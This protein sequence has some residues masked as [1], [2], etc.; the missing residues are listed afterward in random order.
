MSHSDSQP[1][2]A[3]VARDPQAASDS[4]AVT[5]DLS[6]KS[7]IENEETELLSQSGNP[8]L[9]PLEGGRWRP[10]RPDE[11]LK[12]PRAGVDEET[13]D[14]PAD[15]KQAVQLERRQELE[16]KLRE[17][18]T[19]LDGFLELAS[20]YREEERP[21][22]AKR[23]LTQAAQIFPEEERVRYQLEE[24]ILARSLQQFREVSELAHRLKTAEA[25]RELERS[26]SDWA[27]RRIDV[28]RARLE[29]DPTQTTLRMALAEAKF[30]AELFEDSFAEAGRLLELDEFAPAAHF[31]RARCLIAI[32]KDLAAMKELRAVALRKAVIAPTRLKRP[33]LKMLNELSEKLGLDA[34][35]QQY[36]EHLERMESSGSDHA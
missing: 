2:D 21:L 17:N 9:G 13:I 19:D 7:A 26:R 25:Q 29:R 4:D 35:G 20:I 15:S 36:R 24:A 28:C 18:P 27:C 22:E 6:R 3:D 8:D 31:L 14:S 34:T 23:L 1:D 32:G 30:D 5:E 16:H 11:L 33:A 10:V 12:K